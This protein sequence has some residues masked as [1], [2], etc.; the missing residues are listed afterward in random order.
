[1]IDRLANRSVDRRTVAE[2]ERKI[3]EQGQRNVF[4]RF[5]HAKE[6]KEAMAAWKLDLNR[7]LHIFNV[8]SINPP[9]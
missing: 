3:V 7:I 1:M 8:C 9:R 2:I 4:S 6:D 5:F